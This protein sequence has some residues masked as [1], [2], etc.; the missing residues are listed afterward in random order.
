MKEPLSI[1]PATEG[2]NF[3]AGPYVILTIKWR[4]ASEMMSLTLTDAITEEDAEEVARLKNAEIEGHL[5][6]N[7]GFGGWIRINGL[8]IDMTAVAA[9]GAEVIVPHH[10]DPR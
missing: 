9:I 8:A 4:D 6:S 7:S 3:P 1:V 10:C 5:R 2:P